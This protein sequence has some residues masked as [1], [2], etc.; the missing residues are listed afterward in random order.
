VECASFGAL[1]QLVAHPL[2]I[3]GAMLPFSV[4]DLFL[5]FALPL[6][7][8]LVV[9]RILRKPSRRLL[10]RIKVSRQERHRFLHWTRLT[11]RAVLS[12]MA[13]DHA[14]RF[15]AS[16]LL[17]YAF[18]VLF[19]LIGLS[20]IGIDLSS[21]VVLFGVLGIG[22][23]FG[24]QNVIANFFAGLVIFVS[25]P[26]KVGDRILVNG[27]EGD[28]VQIRL[29]ASVINTVANLEP[30]VLFRS[31]DASGITCDLRTWINLASDK[32]V[33][34]SWQNLEI[35]RELKHAGIVIPFPQLDRNTDSTAA[36]V[37]DDTRLDQAYIDSEFLV[38]SRGMYR[39]F[40]RDRRS[41]PD[42][43]ELRS[44]LRCMR[45]MGM[46][47]PANRTAAM[48]TTTERCISAAKRK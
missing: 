6:V 17:R 7:A 38:K 28:V 18:L 14:R 44:L 32:M 15:S 29:I 47:P 2:H 43:G 45:V 40:M 23:G 41:I 5:K 22:V 25:R 35:W 48:S 31:F 1:S 36:P 10:L 27:F 4:L 20:F 19:I 11:A 8:L 12:R 16:N 34:H 26:I 46:C 21:L 9:R 30:L 24:L 13:I 42:H 39:F 3:D 37:P 33:A